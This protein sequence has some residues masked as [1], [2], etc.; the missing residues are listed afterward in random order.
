MAVTP[1]IRILHFIPRRVEFDSQLRGRFIPF[2]R[3]QA[4]LLDLIAGRHG[5]DE[6]GP[7]IVVSVWE[8]DAIVAVPPWSDQGLLDT[9]AAV[10]E[11]GEPRL[12][13]MPVRVRFRA[14]DPDHP[15]LL[16]VFRG[17]VRPGDLDRYV[18]AVENGT[19][20][21][22]ASGRGPLALYLA[23]VESTPDQFVTVSTWSDWSVIEAATGGDIRR[24]VSTRHSEHLVA[25]EAT[26]YEVIEL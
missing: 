22:A 9:A 3:S 26:H 4:G 20:A 19:R 24:P 10:D 17:R 6:R 13:V 14:G 8:P 16:R 11:A 21:D 2:L 5:P 7:R 23:T 15:R 12:E 25:S 1:V 18:D